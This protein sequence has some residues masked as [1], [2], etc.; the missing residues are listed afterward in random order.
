ML[1]SVRAHRRPHAYLPRR[2]AG[3]PGGA[4]SP[5]RAALGCDLDGASGRLL[6]GAA[7]THHLALL[8]HASEPVGHVYPGKRGGEP[9]SLY[10]FIAANPDVRIICAHWGGGLPFYAL[11]PEVR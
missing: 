1:S 11:M 3:A 10:R 2:Y 9:G 4:V 6:A 5:R 7:R 8:F